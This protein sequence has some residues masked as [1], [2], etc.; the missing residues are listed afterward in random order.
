MKFF[1]VLFVVALVSAV[2]LAAIVNSRVE[3][4]PANPHTSVKVN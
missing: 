3:P 1:D 4:I 2:F